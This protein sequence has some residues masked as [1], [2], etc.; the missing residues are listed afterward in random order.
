TLIITAIVV[1]L[2]DVEIVGQLIILLGMILMSLLFTFIAAPI[3][4]A[5]RKIV[6]YV[7]SPG[8]FDPSFRIRV[9]DPTP[10]LP[11][12]AL[13]FVLCGMSVILGDGVVYGVNIGEPLFSQKIG[14]IML[15]LALLVVF[16]LYVGG[17]LISITIAES[18]WQHERKLSIL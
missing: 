1:F 6:T 11:T 18:F 12:I 9:I 2:R 17:L 8:K 7:L 15:I 16:A 14:G 4:E 10:I 5:I 13:V 3:H